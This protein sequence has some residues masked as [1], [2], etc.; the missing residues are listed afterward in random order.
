[1]YPKIHFTAAA[2][3]TTV[4]IDGL[5]TEVALVG[6]IPSKDWPNDSVVKWS[7]LDAPPAIGSKVSPKCS[8]RGAPV[9]YFVNGTVLRYVVEYGFLYAVV[10][11]PALPW[12]YCGERY[13]HEGEKPT[14]CWVAGVD[15]MTRAQQTKIA[16]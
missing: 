10:D 2:T 13:N 9:K 4:L 14:V 16:E 3:L 8:Y 6:G 1:M 11:F 15:L 7:G 12:K 5:P